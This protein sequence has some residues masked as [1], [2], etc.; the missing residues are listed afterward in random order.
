ML[1]G[2]AAG[3]T[4][5]VVGPGSRVCGDDPSLVGVVADVGTLRGPGR[6]TRPKPGRRT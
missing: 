6:I 5:A 4:G 3:A 2:Q 1:F